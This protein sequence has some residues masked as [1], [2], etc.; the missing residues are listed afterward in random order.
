MAEKT[1]KTDKGFEYLDR[2]KDGRIS[3]TELA[4]GLTTIGHHRTPEQVEAMFS[5]FDSDKDGSIDLNEFFDQLSTVETKLTT[6]FKMLDKDKDG[7]ITATE[8]QR[9]SNELGMPLTDEK[10]DELIELYDE[11]GDGKIELQEFGRMMKDLDPADHSQ[12]EPACPLPN[13]GVSDLWSRVDHIALIVSD[14]G[15]SA[16][17]YGTKLGMIQ[18]HRPDFD[19][20]GAWFTMGNIN[21]HLIKGRPAVHADDDLIVSHFAINVGT[22]ADMMNLISRL[23]DLGIP[24]RENISVPNPGEGTNVAVKQAFVRDPDGHYIEFCSCKTLEDYIEEK[25]KEYEAG[26]DLYKTTIAME[27]KRMMSLWGTGEKKPKAD[28]AKLDNLLKRQTT[29]GDITQSATRDQLEELLVLYKNNVPAVLAGLKAIV[30]Q[31]GGQTF[32]P[33]AFYERD[34]TLFQPPGWKMNPNQ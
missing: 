17:F 10:V 24:Y 2:N 31:A 9:M 26:W 13:K 20:H 22:R 11:D 25:V 14:V 19:R 6:A 28:P 15:R 1:D 3:V 27:L 5:K 8:L 18:V 30:K 16:A 7:R 23:N 21:L 34:Q 29:F 33:P 4:Q 12:D 32:I